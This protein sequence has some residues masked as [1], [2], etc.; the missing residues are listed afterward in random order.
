MAIE[1]VRKLNSVRSRRGGAPPQFL[2]RTLK[3]DEQL[4]ELLA[5]EKKDTK[6]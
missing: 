1:F 6:I 4:I 5:L 2:C 3:V